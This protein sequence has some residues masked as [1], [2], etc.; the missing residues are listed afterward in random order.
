MA[1]PTSFLTV[2]DKVITK[3]RLEAGDRSQVKDWINAAYA[4]ST[5]ESECLQTSATTALTA[6]VGAYLMPAAVLRVKG[7]VGHGSGTTAYGPPLIEVSVDEILRMRAGNAA[8]TTGTGTVTHYALVGMNQLEVY[9]VPVAADS[10]LVFYVYAPT[11]LTADDAVPAIPEP[12]G[13]KLLEYGALAEGA[14]FNKDPSELEYRS[15]FEDWI[16]RFRAHLRRRA[17][18]QTGQL[19][20]FPSG[21][22]VPS[23]PGRDLVFR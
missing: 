11:P 21:V 23:D 16:R 22:M 4:L 3:L 15:L 7:I 14:D 18:P 5:L 17:S 12:Y 20:V 1:Y 10:L 9:P 19:Q 2:Q 13:G 6:N 8:S